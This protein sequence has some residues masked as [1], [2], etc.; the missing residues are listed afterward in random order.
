MWSEAPESMIQGAHI[1]EVQLRELE[2]LKLPVCAKE[3]LGVLDKE[4]DFNNLMSCSTCSLLKE[5]FSAS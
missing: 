5:V 1:F 4:L 3:P 2:V